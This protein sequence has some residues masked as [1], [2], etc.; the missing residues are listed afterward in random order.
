MGADRAAELLTRLS[1]D[2][3]SL[4]GRDIYELTEEYADGYPLDT[5]RPFLTSND[6]S[7]QQTVA[8]VLSELGPAA[9]PLVRDVVPLAKSPVVR[10]RYDALEVFLVCAKGTNA[11]LFSHVLRALGDEQ[12]VV[13]LFVMRLVSRAQR[14][15]IV[16]GADALFEQGDI[17]AN[18]A[19]ILKAVGDGTLGRDSV[20]ALVE[21]ANEPDH[22]YGMIA[23]RRGGNDYAEER[24]RLMPTLSADDQKFLKLR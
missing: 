20:L 9:A 5:L 19:G 13:R 8:A 15:Q 3:A 12:G 10:A 4:R 11:D 22:T 16:A 17:S 18:Q 23:L 14:E 21:A 2:P 6:E 24:E 1:T 7:V